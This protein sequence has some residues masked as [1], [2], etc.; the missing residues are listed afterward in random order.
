M[1]VA[2]EP[3]SCGRAC[4]TRRVVDACRAGA[5]S[6]T[7]RERYRPRLAEPREEPRRLLPRRGRVRVRHL[8]QE[9]E[10]ESAQRWHDLARVALREPAEHGQRGRAERVVAHLEV[11]Q[12]QLDQPRLLQVH[13]EWRREGLQRR[14]PRAARRLE[15]REDQHLLEQLDALTHRRER[16]LA[17][18]ALPERRVVRRLARA[19]VK[20]AAARRT[21]ARPLAAAAEHDEPQRRQRGA[22]LAVGGRPAADG[23][24]GGGA[25]RRGGGGGEGRPRQEGADGRRRGGPADRR[26]RSRLRLGSE[27]GEDG[28]SP[29]GRGGAN[30]DR[31]VVEAPARMGRSRVGA[32]SCYSAAHAAAAAL[33]HGGE[34]ETG[35]GG[36]QQARRDGHVAQAAQRERELRDPLGPLLLTEGGVKRRLSPPPPPPPAPPLLLRLARAGA[37]REERRCAVGGSNHL[38]AAARSEETLFTPPQR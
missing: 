7:G 25:A 15:R 18:E 5:A 3:S 34:H 27:G 10:E 6:G 32:G 24:V 8:R 22:A 26:R 16:A 19:V 12:Q 29:D 23:A 28:A 2:C 36:G 9:R 31:A 33:A 13:V 37:G 38:R 11:G 1:G 30:L 4:G 17:G 14:Q 21:S 20:E 35:Q